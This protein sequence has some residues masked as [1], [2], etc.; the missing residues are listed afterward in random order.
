MPSG[1]N[2]AQTV[3]LKAGALQYSAF[4]DP[5][6]YRSVVHKVYVNDLPAPL[7]TWGFGFFF[8]DGIG[9]TLFSYDF[10]RRSVRVGDP[11]DENV[12]EFLPFRVEL[13]YRDENRYRVSV[14]T[15]IRLDS[16]TFT[17]GDTP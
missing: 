13:A 2:F 1:Q 3:S 17:Y 6:V 12:L 10:V 9:Q 15:L 5:D 11:A 16:R 8:A 4:I 7:G 14:S